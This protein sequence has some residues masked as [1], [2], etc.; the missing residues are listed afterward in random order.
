MAAVIACALA[1]AALLLVDI[2]VLKDIFNPT[3]P[4]IA[5]RS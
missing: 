3:A 2:P 1:M 4:T 5:D